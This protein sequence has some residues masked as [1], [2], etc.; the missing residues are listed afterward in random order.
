MSGGDQVRLCGSCKRHVYNV[1]AMSRR[2]L[3][4]LIAT[5]EGKAPCFRIF[6]R[7]DGTLV[8]RRCFDGVRRAARRVWLEACA[9]AALAVAFWMDVVL[10]RDF[11]RG[12]HFSVA[13]P[14][15]DATPAPAAAPAR[16][17]SVTRPREATMG[18]LGTIDWEDLVEERRPRRQR[19]RSAGPLPKS[20]VVRAMNALRGDAKLCGERFGAQGVLMMDVTFMPNG[21]VT[22]RVTG[23]HAGTSCARAMEKAASRLSVPRSDGL[24]TAYPIVIR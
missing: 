14:A 9:L 15:V 4:R 8:T 6:R 22:A 2:E 18:A 16:S 17:G 10:L 19:S 23:R 3:D 1:A 7:A 24:R 21:R 11:I 5:H 20:E 13:P 12:D